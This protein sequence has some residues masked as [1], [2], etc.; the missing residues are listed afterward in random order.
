MNQT[1]RTTLAAILV[2]LTV[3]PDGRAQQSSPAKAAGNLSQPADSDD[4]AALVNEY[5]HAKRGTVGVSI[6]NISDGG[7]VFAYRAKGLFIPASNQK[8]LTSAFALQRLGGDFE[9]V[10][11]I[12]LAGDDLVVFGDFDPLLGD[13]LLAGREKVSIYRD[14]D[15]WAAAV[16]KKVGP[17]VKG[18]LVLASRSDPKQFCQADW[19]KRARSRWYGAPVADLNFHNNCFD[20]TFRKASPTAPSGSP[21]P[22]VAPASRFIKI[23]DRTK[24]GKKQVWRLT[25]DKHDSVVTVTGKV[26]SASSSPIS[27]PM[28]NPPFVLGWV[29]ADRLAREGVTLGGTVRRAP[30]DRADLATAV[31]LAETKTPLTKVIK[32][33]NKR[34]LNMAAECM[35]LRAGDGA[36]PG[37]AK[38]MTDTLV[39]RFGLNAEGLAVR[40]GSG[41]SKKNRVSPKNLTSLL[42]AMARRGDGEILLESLPRSG[43]DGTLR[44]RLRTKTTRGRIAAKTGYLASVCC[45]SGYVLDEKGKPAFAFSILINKVRGVAA[46]KKLQDRICSLLVKKVDGN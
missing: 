5:E 36:W 27:A 21:T 12:Y 42:V 46:A 31:R 8:L 6:V 34:S 23:I 22:V 35:L 25:S 7:E 30:P 41:L 9:F 19:T 2:L 40:D 4:L 37:S 14:L 45:I 17:A 44:R 3:L 28:K 39:G 26:K 29:L 1:L 16:K 38:I 15:R 33:A 13:S 20:V 18:D 10:T 11:R 32:R 43:I 24:P